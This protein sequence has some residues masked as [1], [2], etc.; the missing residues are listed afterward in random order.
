MSPELAAKSYDILLA[1]KDGFAP[2]AEIDMTG[3]RT[4]LALRSEYGE[5]RKALTDPAKYIDLSYYKKAMA[6]AK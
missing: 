4:V 2:K 5:P 6:K 1:P 3:V